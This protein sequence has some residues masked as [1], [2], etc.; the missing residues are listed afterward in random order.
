MY[1]ATAIRSG[2]IMGSNR[3]TETSLP[4]IMMSWPSPYDMFRSSPN[5]RLLSPRAQ[6]EIS[7]SCKSRKF[8]TQDH[9]PSFVH[10]LAAVFSERWF[11]KRPVAPDIASRILNNQVGSIKPTGWI[12]LLQQFH[13]PV[14]LMALGHVEGRARKQGL[15]IMSKP[16]TPLTL[17]GS[18]SEGEIH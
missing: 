18:S 9:L 8:S 3:R 12:P 10:F 1:S 6:Q 13:D 16:A 14:V 11:K 17:T 15:P 4:A 2:L 5:R 7:L